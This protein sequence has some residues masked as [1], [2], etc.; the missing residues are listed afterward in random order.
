MNFTYSRSAR[1]PSSRATSRLRGYAFYTS[2]AELWCITDGI[3]LLRTSKVLLPP[4][5]PDMADPLSIAASAVGFIQLLNQIYNLGA[6]FSSAREDQRQAVE[7]FQREVQQLHGLLINLHD[8]VRETET[9]YGFANWTMELVEL[10]ECLEDNKNGLERFAIELRQHSNSRWRR[11]VG[12]LTWPIK[13]KDK[14]RLFKLVDRAKL[15]I[16][17]TL[18]VRQVYVVTLKVLTKEELIPL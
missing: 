4:F 14:R 2:T 7:E 15:N 5:L 11:F 17:T 9:A 6:A 3:R 16:T 13:E 12:R 8:L 1:S 10:Q 18:G